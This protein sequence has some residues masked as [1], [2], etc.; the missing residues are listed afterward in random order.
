M[1]GLG[2]WQFLQWINPTSL[3]FP[4][5]WHSHW[6]SAE[7]NKADEMLPP[8]ILPIPLTGAVWGGAIQLGFDRWQVPQKG[9]GL[10]F[11][12]VQ[13]AQDQGPLCEVLETGA[14]TGAGLSGVIWVVG[15]A[16]GGNCRLPNIRV[17]KPGS[18][19]N[20]A[21]GPDWGR[22]GRSGLTGSDRA[23]ARVAGD[24]S[25]HMTQCSLPA[26]LW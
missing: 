14:A 18:G 7:P 20:R 3:P 11:L 2:S 4:H 21:S 1:W 5:L 15:V 24:G 12:N 19:P 22:G 6:G 13:L 26:R 9:A 17:M 10:G 25:L 8:G 16:E 23:C